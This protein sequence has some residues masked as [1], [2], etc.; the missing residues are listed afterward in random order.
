MLLVAKVPKISEAD[1]R[2][3]CLCGKFNEA[4]VSFWDLKVNVNFGPNESCFV[5][6]EISPKSSKLSKT[7]GKLRPINE[8]IFSSLEAL[9]PKVSRLFVKMDS[10]AFATHFFFF[11]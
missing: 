5:G 11:Y 9:D 6:S 1:F 2:L 7:Y 3:T 4:R 8:L 10:R